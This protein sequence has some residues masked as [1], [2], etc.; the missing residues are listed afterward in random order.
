MHWNT[1]LIRPAMPTVLLLLLLLLLPNHYSVHTDWLPC[2]CVLYIVPILCCR[3][4]FLICNFPNEF[5]LL[6]CFWALSSHQNAALR[7]YMLQHKYLIT[8]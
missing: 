3:T 7:T 2:F 4:C 8:G 1:L 6:I 5:C